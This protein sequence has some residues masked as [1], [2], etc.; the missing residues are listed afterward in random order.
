[1]NGRKWSP[2][3]LRSALKTARG[4]G[5]PI[6]LLVENAQFFRTYSIPYREGEK[7]PHLERIA[8]QPDLLN[9]LLAPLTH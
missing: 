3:V 9:V 7:N 6:E 2:A 1:V 5:A 4:T 8:G